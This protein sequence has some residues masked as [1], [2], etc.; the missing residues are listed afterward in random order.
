M[1]RRATEGRSSSPTSRRLRWPAPTRLRSG[2]GPR[3][4]AIRSRWTT[5]PCASPSASASLSSRSMDG[6]SRPWSPAPTARFTMPRNRAAIGSRWNRRTDDLS[7]GAD[8]LEE[9]PDLP[10]LEN[11]VALLGGI[12]DQVDEVLPGLETALLQPEDHVR[13]AGHRPDPYRLRIAEVRGGHSRVHPVCE[14][15]VVL[16]Q[17]LDDRGGMYAGPGLEG[18]LA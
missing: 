2:S 6:I 14:P 11:V 13:P 4:S 12:E 8:R 10:V 3:S 16:A 5:R 1:C 7:G 15:E 9:R 17:R 18:I